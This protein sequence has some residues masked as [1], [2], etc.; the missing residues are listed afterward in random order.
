MPSI[1][2]YGPELEVS[3]KKDLISSF[4]EATNKVTGI[5]KEAVTI[6]LITSPPDTVGIG[7]ELISERQERLRGQSK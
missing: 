4:T 6:H 7:G 2:F 5:R 3:K 1:F